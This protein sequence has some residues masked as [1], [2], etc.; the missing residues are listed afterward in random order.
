MAPGSRSR[1]QPAPSQIAAEARARPGSALS[2]S[3]PFVARMERI[4]Q[5]GGA[6]TRHRP[7]I[8]LR[9][10]PGYV[11][12]IHH[13]KQPSFFSPGSFLRPGSSP[14]FSPSSLPTPSEGLAERRETS[15]LVR[16]AQ[17]TRDA[18]LARHGPSRATGRPASRRSAVALSAQ[19]PPPSPVPGPAR[20]LHA[21][22][23]F[24][25]EHGARLFVSAVTSRGR[26]HIPLRLQD[27]LRRR[28]SMSG[29]C[30]T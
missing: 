15:S 19:V 30:A 14:S 12:P 17:V 23:A 16:V 20:R 21:A 13:V 29:I 25:P 11:L 7:R 22:Q 6:P 9:L 8:S 1:A 5:C 27:R 4:A 18:T 24:L 28:P 2:P 3:T 10:D 26:R